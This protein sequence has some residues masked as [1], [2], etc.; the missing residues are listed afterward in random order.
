MV[1]YYRLKELGFR[2][3]AGAHVLRGGEVEPL[4]AATALLKAAE[5]E[6]ERIRQEARDAYAAEK[7]RGFEEGLEQ[8]RMQAVG[9]IVEES[10]VLDDAL[11]DIDR[12]LTNLVIH[13]VRKLVDGFSDQDKAEA[14]VRAALKQMRR[15]KR[16]QLAVAPSQIE[17][18]R[19]SI[20]DIK[21][22]FPEIDLIDVVED[23]SLDPPRIIVE[24]PVGRVDGHFAQRID[25]LEAILR[26]SA[27]VIAEEDAAEGAHR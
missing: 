18:F 4:D 14:M 19:R 9:R 6:A 27:V 11:R 15:E 7:I 24:S 10:R 5:Q 20:G 1:G 23:P 13:A 2:L 12:D 16:I 26:R 21:A 17:H 25:E 8:A 22:S 3:S